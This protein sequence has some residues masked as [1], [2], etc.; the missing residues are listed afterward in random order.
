MHGSIFHGLELHDSNDVEV[1]IMSL[2]QF[3]QG[4]MYSRIMSAYSIL[5]NEQ[6]L[7]IKLITVSTATCP[8][9]ALACSLAALILDIYCSRI[10]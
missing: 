1:D 7:L 6:I 2:F 5:N 4:V 3:N 10:Q 9:N 8:N